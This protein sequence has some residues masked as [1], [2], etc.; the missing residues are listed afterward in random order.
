MPE[1]TVCITMFFVTL[2]IEINYAVV[3]NKYTGITSSFYSSSQN[4][5]NVQ[6]QIE[7]DCKESGE[8]CAEAG[9]SRVCK[10]YVYFLPV[11][12]EEVPESYLSQRGERFLKTVRFGNFNSSRQ[13]MQKE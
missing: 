3:A 4:T 9:T 12:P 10:A 11:S 1:A 2:Q 6:Q 8:K 5:T 13:V 7:A